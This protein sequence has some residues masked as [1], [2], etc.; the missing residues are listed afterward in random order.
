MKEK[1]KNTAGIVFLSL[2]AMSCAFMALDILSRPFLSS[3]SPIERK[4]SV[5]AARHPQPYTMFGGLKHARHLEKFMIPGGLNRMGYKGQVP[6][7]P[8]TTGEYRII[9]LGGSTVLIG[10]PSIPQLLETIFTENGH[11]NVKVYNF[12]VISSVSGQELAR[13]V[14]EV[15]DYDPDLIVMYN[16]ANDILSPLTGDP[17]PGYPFNFIVYENNPLLDKDISDYPLFTLMAYGSNIIRAAFPAYFT[18]KFVRL[19]ELRKQIGW[20]SPEW[21]DAV[22]RAYVDNIS[23]AQRISAAFGTDF[24]AFFQPTVYYKDMLHPWEKKRLNPEVCAYAQKIRKKINKYSAPILHLSEHFYDLGDLY[25]QRQNFIFLDE[26]HTLQ[27]AKPD[28][29]QAMYEKISTRIS[30]SR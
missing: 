24:I 4:F 21:E 16:G 28:A 11:S 26:M 9:M 15:S 1:I 17:R 25:D 12:G 10:N 18:E 13:I 19:N 8:K 23:K 22:A 27:F 5:T 3:R 7:I 29:A 20:K 6:K 30:Q 14:F 2:M